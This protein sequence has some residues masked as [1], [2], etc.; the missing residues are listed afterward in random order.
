MWSHTLFN[1]QC[2]LVCLQTQKYRE[3]HDWWHATCYNLSSKNCQHVCGP[4][5]LAI[6]SVSGDVFRVFWQIMHPPR[7]LALEP[8]LLR[9][10]LSLS[11]IFIVT[12]C[13]PFSVCL[14]LLHVLFVVSPV[15]WHSML[16]L[17]RF[18]FWYIQYMCCTAWFLIYIYMPISARLWSRVDTDSL[19]S[20]TTP[21]EKILQSAMK[22]FTTGQDY[23]YH[24]DDS[25]Q[26]VSSTK[27]QI[28][29]NTCFNKNH[30]HNCTIAH[31]IPP[32][33]TVVTVLGLSN[34]PP[35]L[36]RVLRIKRSMV[37]VILLT[38]GEHLHGSHF[39]VDFFS[40][41][42]YAD[43]TNNH[44]NNSNNNTEGSNEKPFFIM[45]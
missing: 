12:F 28:H 6:S 30:L 1:W 8:A 33:G 20:I 41:S 7:P 9:E 14:H 5:A 29:F 17:Y 19:W 37:D 22:R 44:H 21:G 42:L 13:C 4:D 32:K 16:L 10:S 39:S 43:P 38:S 18:T 23:H 3:G 27:K 31:H 2:F 35:D 15:E 36:C 25:V 26:P 34:K 40:V 45:C 24:H 11:H